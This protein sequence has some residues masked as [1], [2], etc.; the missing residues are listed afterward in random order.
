MRIG[1]DAKRAL[2]NNTGLGN[3]SRYVLRAF[4]ENRAEDPGMSMVLFSPKAPG[5][6]LKRINNI[7]DDGVAEIATPH[8]A[9]HRRF[10]ALWRTW[11]VTGDI[12][13]R[14][15]DIY[16][17]LSNELPLTLAKSTIPA[18]VTV[19]DV[20][21]RRI[22]GDYNPID[23]RLYDFKYGRSMRQADRIIAI[24][25]CTAD[26]IVS[27]FGIDPARIDVI[28]QGCDSSF[29]PRTHAEISAIRDTYG[30][31]T[32]PYIISVG[33][34]QSRK[35]QLLAVKAL[36]MIPHDVN[37]A[38]IG[39]HTPYAR[40]ITDF[41]S[42]RPDLRKRVFFLT[43]VPFIHLPALYS[44]AVCSAYVSR[45]EG[46]GIPLIESLSCG[47]PCIGAT[48][49]CLK[50]AAGDG[51][52]YC[53]PDSPEEFAAHACA[54]I[55]SQQLHDTLAHNGRRHIAALNTTSFVS[56]TR[57]CYNKAIQAKKQGYQ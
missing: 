28:R 39:R 23:R 5:D 12:K 51:A 55:E 53:S 43:S 36:P 32:A 57:E 50:E 47:T 54:I 26:D 29:T 9:I 24:S 15:I 49:S 41:L 3:Y 34:V 33:T 30:L 6:G 7:L 16:H 35:N 4:A 18:V 1:F 27:D 10:G 8:H 14:G 2:C 46:F 25:Q 40:E 20:I 37:L 11:A 22:P 38:I 52:L 21:W 17:G 42:T 44:G 13:A 48:G 45:Y 19:H 31:G 56:L